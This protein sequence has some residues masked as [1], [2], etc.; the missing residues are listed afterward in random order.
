MCYSPLIFLWAFHL[1]TW[2]VSRYT[3]H[4]TK[5]YTYNE[6]LC[7]FGIYF[8]ET[9]NLDL[10]FFVVVFTVVFLT[11][12]LNA[13]QLSELWTVAIFWKQNTDCSCLLSCCFSFTFFPNPPPQL[14]RFLPPPLSLPLSPSPLFSLI[15]R[16]PPTLPFNFWHHVSFSPLFSSLCNRSVLW[17]RSVAPSTKAWK[18]PIPE[19]PSTTSWRTLSLG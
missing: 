4:W 19:H 12:F 18:N 9:Y 17:M 13:R 11:V 5:A 6:R 16:V 7:S 14:A 10:F 3:A 15:P 8:L 2:L 1:L